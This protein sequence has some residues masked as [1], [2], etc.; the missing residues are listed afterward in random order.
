ADKD[1]KADISILNLK[2]QVVKSWQ[3]TFIKQG[4]SDFYWDGKDNK[5]RD[6]SSGV[7]FWKVQSGETA[8][9]NK[10]LYLK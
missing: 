8:F 1:F 4:N 6:I 5:G 9:T 2:G 7:Y 10:I 3:N